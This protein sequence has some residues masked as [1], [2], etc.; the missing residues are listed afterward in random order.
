MVFRT[1]CT[2]LLVS[3]GSSSVSLNLVSTVH[4]F[5]SMWGLL[6]SS[7]VSPTY[8][9]L[10]LRE[11]LFA[12]IYLCICTYVL[13][14][15]KDARPYV[16]IS[17][18]SSRL[19]LLSRLPVCC[20]FSTI[21]FLFIHYWCRYEYLIVFSPFAKFFIL[22]VCACARTHDFHTNNNNNNAELGTKWTDTVSPENRLIIFVLILQIHIRMYIC[23]HIH[24]YVSKFIRRRVC[25][26]VWV[27]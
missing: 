3:N 22:T 20:C 18:L 25:T 26:I 8:T 17:S 7:A 21:F 11:I 2:S 24:K 1:F 10:C 23:F 19:F 13:S 14:M 12:C 5:M 27:D 4:A 15:F 6:A 16:G 9:Y